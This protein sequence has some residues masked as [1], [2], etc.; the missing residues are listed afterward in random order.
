MN[1]TTQLFTTAPDGRVISTFWSTDTAA[2][3]GWHD[4]FGIPGGT[5]NGLV[6][7]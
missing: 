5:G 4:W 7:I 1:G 6:R 2:N 3:G